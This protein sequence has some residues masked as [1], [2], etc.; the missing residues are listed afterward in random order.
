MLQR[1][2]SRFGAGFERMI[3]EAPYGPSV[4]ETSRGS[5]KAIHLAST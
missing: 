5:V 2:K 1:V 4:T 3:G